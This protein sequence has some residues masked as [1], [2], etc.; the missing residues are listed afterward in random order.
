E[1]TFR[2]LGFALGLY[3]SDFR[4]IKNLREYELIE[5]LEKAKDPYSSGPIF[6]TIKDRI[7]VNWGVSGRDI[8]VFD[9]D[10]KL[11]RL[12]RGNFQ[13][14]PLSRK[15]KDRIIESV[16]DPD[17]EFARKEIEP[18]K[19]FPPFLSFLSDDRDHLI[20]VRPETIGAD[21]NSVCDFFTEDGVRFLR[22]G[23]GFVRFLLFS[24]G[25][26]EYEFVIKNGR[27]YCV[28]EKSSGF[29]EIV[30]YS[31]HWS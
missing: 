18:L 11:L 9:L 20:V 12:I 2:I 7:F 17:K 3:D 22:A 4:L 16:P 1:K 31:M 26:G 29:K 30:V 25:A 10:G 15:D 19:T 13:L 23:L 5:D 8:A 21:G 14:L 6:G 24:E 27:A 28:R